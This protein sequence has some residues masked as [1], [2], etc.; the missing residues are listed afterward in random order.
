MHG[1]SWARLAEAVPTKTLTQI[2][3][4]YQNYKVKVRLRLVPPGAICIP[5]CALARSLPA[6]CADMKPCSVKASPLKRQASYHLVMLVQLVCLASPKPFAF[7]RMPPACMG[8]LGQLWGSIRNLTQRNLS[9]STQ[10][11]AGPGP[12][13]AAAERGAAGLAEA[14]AP[15]RRECRRG[16]ARPGQRPDHRQ[17]LAGGVLFRHTAGTA[18]A[19]RHQ[20]L[21]RIRARAPAGA[22]RCCLPAT[23]WLVCLQVGRGSAANPPQGLQ[24]CTWSRVKASDTGL[25]SSLC[26][27]V[28]HAVMTAGLV[29]L[30]WVVHMLAL[31]AILCKKKRSLAAHHF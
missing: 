6:A 25:L 13:G 2:K 28:P 21:C 1:R 15:R 31:S 17:L 29:P 18:A 7:K 23:P 4:Y 24:F 14:R 30:L 19:Q 11:A 22:C 10:C 9:K 8:H 20:R 27:T 16:R 5:V 26:L 3:N 12:H